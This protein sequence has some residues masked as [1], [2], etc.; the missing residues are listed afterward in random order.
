MYCVAS[1][2]DEQVCR[3]KDRCA[4]RRNG[5][6]LIQHIERCDS[7]TEQA[8]QLVLVVAWMKTAVALSV[9]ETAT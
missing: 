1:G 8:S 9:A 5:G 4:R 7:T 3:E 6:E 2:K